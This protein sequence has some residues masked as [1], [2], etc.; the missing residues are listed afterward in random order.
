LWIAQ[1]LALCKRLA[2]DKRQHRLGMMLQRLPQL[3]RAVKDPR[4]PEHKMALLLMPEPHPMR[5]ANRI[6]PLPRRQAERLRIRPPVNSS[7]EG[8]GPVA[9]GEETSEAPAAAI[10]TTTIAA[11]PDLAEVGSGAT[12]VGVGDPL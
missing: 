8:V 2:A 9:S 3:L 1:Q 5:E 4:H 12:V 6:P 10:R 11:I 7:G